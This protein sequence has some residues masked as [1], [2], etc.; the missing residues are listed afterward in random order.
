[1]N[2]VGTILTHHT[3]KTSPQNGSDVLVVLVLVDLDCAHCVENQN[4]VVAACRHVC[5]HSVSALPQGQVLAVT[6]VVLDVDE[7]LAGISVREH[8]TNTT[9]F[10]HTL[11]E[12]INLCEGTVVSDRLVGAVA[13]GDF[14]LKSS[15]RA[16]EVGEVGLT[17]APT[18]TK[19]TD[20]AA[21][22]P[23]SVRSKRV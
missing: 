10:S 14:M 3:W 2:G 15:I 4:S 19:G 12:H 5:N 16:D 9:D 17:T 1:M 6:K 7:A 8:Q 18:N 21:V 23:A 20:I 11:G 13:R 22:V